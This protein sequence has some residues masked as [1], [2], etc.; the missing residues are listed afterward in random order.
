MEG[1]GVWR[2]REEERIGSWKEGLLHG[3]AIEVIRCQLEPA[4]GLASKSSPG[5][6]SLERYV[7]SFQKGK[8]HGA[9]CLALEAN[10][11]SSRNTDQKEAF[12]QISY[13][14]CWKNG[15]KAGFGL[16]LES[17]REHLGS[18]AE[19][20]PTGIGQLT[21]LDSAKVYLGEFADGKFEGFGRLA[22]DK[23]YNYMG[24]WSGGLKD[25]IGYEKHRNEVY[26]GE[27]RQNKKNGIGYLITADAEYKGEF[28]DGFM[29][30]VG[31]LKNG[32]KEKIVRAISGHYSSESQ[33][34]ALIKHILDFFDSLNPESFFTASRSRINGF[35]QE[36]KDVSHI[37]QNSYNSC[38]FGFDEEVKS[39]QYSFN[40]IRSK[41]SKLETS[42]RLK[43]DSLVRKA[44]E[45]PHHVSEFLRVDSPNLAA[46]DSLKLFFDGIEQSSQT[47]FSGR[48][49]SALLDQAR[50]T[51]QHVER[52]SFT[53]SKPILD[54]GD[55]ERFS[56]QKGRN[57]H[58]RGPF[59]RTE[60]K[61]P[62]KLQ[63]LGGNVRSPSR[64]SGWRVSLQ[65]DPDC[66]QARDAIYDDD[67]FKQ[68]SSM[69]IADSDSYYHPKWRELNAK[70]EHKLMDEGFSSFKDRSQQQRQAT[71]SHK[72][73]Q[74]DQANRLF[75]GKVPALQMQRLSRVPMFNDSSSSD[76]HM[77]S[78]RD[79][80][81]SIKYYQHQT[82]S[83]AQS[84][85][86]KQSPRASKED[87]M[88]MY[89][90]L[91]DFMELPSVRSIQ[92]SKSI[93]ERI[94]EEFN[95]FNKPLEVPAEDSP[96]RGDLDEQNMSLVPKLVS[97]SEVQA[98][99]STTLV[100]HQLQGSQLAE[101]QDTASWHL[102]PKEIKVPHHLHLSST[103]CQAPS[104]LPS[105]DRPSPVQERFHGF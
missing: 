89:S 48:T 49:R 23:Q 12:Q 58:Q 75:D 60:P 15:Q 54:Q 14:G 31:V 47:L 104:P 50:E 103:G 94:P 83:H 24:Y 81:S 79:E 101:S 18:F 36:I 93:G 59:T 99:D 40:S 42:W 53:P 73:Y 78:F 102:G 72:V 9:G 80:L 26:I 45:I 87:M 20:K 68:G 7:G 33:N 25:G 66:S 105:P 30:G 32:D 92:S 38:L 35:T 1:F 95:S 56:D 51:V 6:P 86:R 85:E 100:Q 3:K 77:L 63:G 43:R 90:H 67:S 21:N 2:C 74:P 57:P 46:I 13:I 28:V 61:S 27:W 65:F 44:T 55:Y 29:H 41:L 17:N 39:L 34:T 71:E 10:P 4:I 84:P 64:S 19:G 52:I 76:N 37:V 91:E 22:D 8:R 97:F 88:T 69:R 98:L 11:S 82:T 16:L 70:P 62:P 5:S 96:H